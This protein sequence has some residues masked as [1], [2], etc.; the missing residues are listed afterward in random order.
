[1]R[2]TVAVL[3]RFHALLWLAVTLL[4]LS[5]SAAASADS[6]PM[7]ERHS[8]F[9]ADRRTR[10]VV[11]PNRALARHYIEGPASA[12]RPGGRAR[13]RLERRGSDGRW[14]RLW[15][16][17][18]V[19][20]VS[21]VSALVADSGDYVV[22]FDNW[23]G[24]GTGGDVVVI[25]G[26]GGRLVRSL[27]LSDLLPEDYILALPRTF[28]SIWW[29]GSNDE[30]YLSA[31]GERLVLR[32]ALPSTEDDLGTGGTFELPV[33]LASGE[34]VR[35]GPDWD[36]AMATAVAARAAA[37][38]RQAAYRVFVTEPLTAP[39]SSDR[40][41]WDAYLNE[42]FMRLAP[43]WEMNNPWKMLIRPPG[44]RPYD[45][46]FAPDPRTIFAQ[47]NLPMAIAIASPE[48][49]AI[50]PALAPLVERRR[51]G[52]LRG[53]RLYI[54]ADDAAWPDIVA[55]FRGSGATLVQLDPAEPIPQRPDRV[56]APG[57]APLRPIMFSS[58]P[59]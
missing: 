21:P 8:H 35:S 51:P 18:L 28:S 23:G 20:E 46:A 25:Y 55:L 53:I 29:G 44:A 2:E 33:I 13:G 15:D 16:M 38:Q 31:D 40:S 52:W 27:A 37:L 32:L 3:R 1:M 58:H 57:D 30:H 56:P 7:P 43:D 34:P 4:A 48:G 54:A 5:L 47:R 19:N 22:T 49:V 42:A 45:G 36:R 12:Q 10:L 24:V 26:A 14:R 59:S 11:T 6:W 50:A 39:R 9:S 17:A 41:A